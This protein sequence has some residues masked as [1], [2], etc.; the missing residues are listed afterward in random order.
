MLHDIEEKHLK[1]ISTKSRDWKDS[2][3]RCITQRIG[4]AGRAIG[5]TEVTKVPGESVPGNP[6]CQGKREG[7]AEFQKE[8]VTS[9]GKKVEVV[10]RG[11]WSNVQGL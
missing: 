11:L 10:P 2:S 1:I 7:I 8:Q 3:R 6:R 5:E 4:T 9:K